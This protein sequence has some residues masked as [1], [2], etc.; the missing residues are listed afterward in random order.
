[1]LNFNSNNSQEKS[2]T[3]KDFNNDIWDKR[4]DIFYPDMET[5]KEYPDPE[6]NEKEEA[7]EIKEA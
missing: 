4:A 3:K 6:D 2:K 1:M 5:K 7:D